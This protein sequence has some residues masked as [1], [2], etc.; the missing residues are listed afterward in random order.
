M[1]EL[2]HLQRLWKAER[3][4]DALKLVDQL[5]SKSPD[6]PYL[7]VT[8]GMLIQLLDHQNGPALREAEENFLKALTLAPES[9]D[10]LEELAHFYD[11]VEPNAT[12]AKFYASEY[13]KRAEPALKKI[14]NILNER[15]S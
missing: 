13:V 15:P 12:K 8:R 1:S 9:L 3:F 11:A 4:N 14:R 2:L 5:L 10:A 7:L 6:C